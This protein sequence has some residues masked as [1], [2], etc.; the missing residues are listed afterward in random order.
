MSKLLPKDI[1]EIFQD[2]SERYDFEY[3]EAAWEH[4]EN[5]LEKD[6]RRRFRWWVFISISVVLTLGVIY[7]FI[8]TKNESFSK[9]QIE[10]NLSKIEEPIFQIN[11]TEEKGNINEA[12][13]GKTTPILKN[14]VTTTY[15]NEISLELQNADSKEKNN[16]A[17]TSKKESNDLLTREA[18]ELASGFNILDTLNEINEESR[19]PFKTEENNNMTIF[20]DTIVSM[21]VP[22]AML[23]IL[24]KQNSHSNTSKVLNLNIEK[25]IISPLEEK[26]KETISQKDNS[27]NALLIGLV[28]ATEVSTI[29]RDNI[30]RPD[31]KFGAQLEY[32]FSKRFGTSVG[33]SYIE[34]DYGA[35]DG[36]YIPPM[37]FWTDGVAPELTRGLCDIIEIPVNFT[38]FFNDFSARKNMFYVTGGLTSYIMLRSEYDYFYGEDPPSSDLIKE[39]QVENGRDNLFGVGHVSIGFERFLSN[40]MSIQLAPYIQIPIGEIGHGNVKIWSFGT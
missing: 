35:G 7:L 8:P 9:E 36:E 14:N 1:D 2:G 18:K 26:E 25:A 4:M 16:N 38:Y 27:E 15:P 20:K 11:N 29:G 6:D 28:M 31:F 39:W 5:L 23:D 12:R 40:K 10:N 24:T 33:V 34:K 37:G 21:V 30:C 3:H 13:K 19:I 32:R 17:F 22:L